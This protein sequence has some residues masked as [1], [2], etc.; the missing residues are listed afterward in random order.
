MEYLLCDLMGDMCSCNSDISFI[1]EVTI[2]YVL[3]ICPMVTIPLQH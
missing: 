1:M 3:Y 2:E